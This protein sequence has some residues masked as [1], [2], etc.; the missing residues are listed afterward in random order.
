MPGKDASHSPLLPY[1]AAFPPSSPSPNDGPSPCLHHL[2]ERQA[3]RTPDAVALVCEDRGLAYRELDRQ[4]NRLARR[5]RGVGVGP[6]SLVGLCADRS[7]ELVVAILGILKAGGAYVPLDPD[8]PRERLAVMLED[9]RPAVLVRQAHLANRLP[10][11][12]AEEV[13]LEDNGSVGGPDTPPP[14]D[15]ATADDLAYVIFTSGSTGRPK[16]VMVSHRNVV[17]LMHATWPWFRFDG[18]DVWTLFHSFAFDF[19][20]WEL[21]GALAYGGRLVVVP[22][23]TSRS[24]RAFYELLWRERVTVLNQTP[25]AFRQLM[26]AEEADGAAADLALRL[27]IFGGEALALP[28]LRPWVERHG[29]RHPRLVNM[30]GITETTVFVTYRPIRREDVEAG[31]GSAIGRPIPGWQVCLRGPDGRPVP[32][33]EV[34]EIFVG[35]QGVAH[36]Y[37]NRP[38]LT[39]ERFVPDPT[40]PDPGARLYRSG[41][42]ARRR[43][44]GDLV[45]E[46]RIDHQVKI[47]G[48]RIELLEIES[49]LARHPAVREATVLAREDV[50]GEKR[51]VA[52]VAARPGAGPSGSELR[53]HVRD[54]LPDY[55]VPAAYVFLDRLPMTANGKVNRELLPPPPSRLADR[56][57]GFTEPRTDLERRLRD[58]WEAVLRVRPIGVHDGFFELGGDSL[59]AMN[60]CLEVR[61]GLGRELTPAAF[62]GEATISQMAE[63]LEG[64]SVAGAW[65]SVVA[66]QPRG[67]RPP[68]FCV[69]ALGGQ[70]LGYRLLAAHLGPDQPF[71]G[72]QGQPVHDDTETFPRLEDRAAHYVAE[73]MSVQ[74]HGPYYLGGYSLGA[75]V[76][77]EMAQ[78]LCRQGR[79][80]AFLAML[81]DGPSL[82]QDRSRRGPGE[83]W[84]FLAN[85]PHWMAF[86]AC[87]KSPAAL[88]R[89][90]WRK[91]KVWKRKLLGP[92]MAADV[93]EALDVSRYSASYRRRLANSYLALKTYVPRHYP[94]PVTVFRARTQPLLGVHRP[95]LG[96]GRYAAGGAEVCVVPG[97]HTS[98]LMEPDVATLGARLAEALGR[99][100]RAGARSRLLCG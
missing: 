4:A 79:P 28:T 54:R 31:T 90:V 89:D 88:G 1:P 48:F 49:V 36:G 20:V 58:V 66:I 43:P 78:Q 52:Y 74:P 68:F 96:W 71:Y 81:D 57:A 34:G 75:F 64:E 5:L 39:A 46:G 93:E 55:M 29:D 42:L 85:A 47:R 63:A 70:V 72:L 6:G 37:L 32:D 22:H 95:D 80:V 23:A 3:R 69:H 73:L 19:S 44:D 53:G 18:R 84:N 33:G 30:Y 98:M 60:L 56:G 8:Y 25:S 7:P 27:V 2:F 50:P 16:G 35:G 87:R 76:A 61:K 99:A 77:F 100:Q 82:V 51:L 17:A 45:Y 67:S 15:R 91:L 92:A 9:A 24:P 12:Q 10:A 59:L 65:S 83:V 13:L 86:Q 14:P 38:D 94:G 41:D 40:S 26:Q 62:F 21:W 97:D 11:H